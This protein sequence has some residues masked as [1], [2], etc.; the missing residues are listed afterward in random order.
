[1]PPTR[2]ETF[3]I[4]PLTNEEALRT[5]LAEANFRTESAEARLSVQ[6]AKFSQDYRQ[7][8]NPLSQSNPLWCPP[9][10]SDYSESQMGDR[11]QRESTAGKRFTFAQLSNMQSQHACRPDFDDHG[12]PGKQPSKRRVSFISESRSPLRLG[13]TTNEFNAG[14][15]AQRGRSISVD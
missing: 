3:L 15:Q 11:T 6:N 8:I 4:S 5:D 1:M 9:S 12:I 7:P 14:G 10:Q 13:P 2:C